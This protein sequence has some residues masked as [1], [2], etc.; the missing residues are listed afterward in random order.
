MIIAANFKFHLSSFVWWC[1]VRDADAVSMFLS[2]LI[3][4]TFIMCI[5]IF[6]KFSKV[7]NL[8]RIEQVVPWIKTINIPKRSMRNF[9]LTQ[10]LLQTSLELI[11]LNFLAVSIL[12]IHFIRWTISVR[13]FK[14]LIKEVVET[15]RWIVISDFRLWVC[16]IT[17]LFHFH[18]KLYFEIIFFC[19]C[20]LI[21]IKMKK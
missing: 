12:I 14:L 13:K 10:V 21:K 7:C 18:D 3:K 19:K 6:C 9:V 2:I 5:F 1:V 15:T 17:Y 20:Q 8:I 16:Y 11:V 4:N